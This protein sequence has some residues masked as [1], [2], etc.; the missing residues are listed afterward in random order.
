MSPSKRKIF[1][2]AWL[3]MAMPS[4]GIAALQLYAMLVGLY[5]PVAHDQM[6]PESVA[7]FRAGLIAAV[8]VAIPTSLVA[9]RY[10]TR[11]PERA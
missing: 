5:D 6:S 2:I 3:L 9:F 7:N 10:V 8:L 4:G 1:A 11:A